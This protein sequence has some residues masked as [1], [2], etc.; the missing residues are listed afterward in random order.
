MLELTE[1]EVGL[2]R[3]E[4]IT[5]CTVR[6][7]EYCQH[8]QYRRVLPALTEKV[9]TASIVSTGEYCQHCQNR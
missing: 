3:E 8:C 9:S 1:K 2:A 5:A 4:E 7:G 6:T